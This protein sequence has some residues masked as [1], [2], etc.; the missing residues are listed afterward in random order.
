VQKIAVWFH[1]CLSSEYTVS[2]AV[3]TNCFLLLQI[4]WATIHCPFTVEEGVG[5]APDSYAIDGKRVR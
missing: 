3:L 5:D 2:Q 1:S 4:G